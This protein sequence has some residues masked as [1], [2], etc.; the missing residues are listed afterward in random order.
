MGRSLQIGLTS[1]LEAGKGPLLAGCPAI[2]LVA[3][4]EGGPTLPWSHS[5][6]CPEA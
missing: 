3:V 2:T 1:E 5:P 4:G 6:C